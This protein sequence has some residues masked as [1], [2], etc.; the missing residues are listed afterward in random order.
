MSSKRNYSTDLLRCIL[1]IM[2]TAHHIIVH[3]LDLKVLGSGSVATDRFPFSLF[4][5]NSFCII[6]VNAF[7]FISGYFQSSIDD[8]KGLLNKYKKSIYRIGIP[9][10]VWGGVYVFIR[11]RSIW[12]A[13]CSDSIPH[14][15]PV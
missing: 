6:A 13:S 5:L 14:C 4:L 7:F 8:F 3:T 2:I 9:L 12:A 1:M 11:F 15:C 10:I